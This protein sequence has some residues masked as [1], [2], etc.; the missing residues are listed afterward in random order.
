M[1]D[2][3]D[4]GEAPERPKKAMKKA[5]RA[6]TASTTAPEGVVA[7]SAARSPGELTVERAPSAAP[8]APASLVPVPKELVVN[9]FDNLSSTE[10]PDGATARASRERSFGKLRRAKA[11]ES[12][13]RMPRRTPT[14]GRPKSEHHRLVSPP[15]LL[16]LSLRVPHPCH[17][18]RH[19]PL[20]PKQHR[21]QS[22]AML[23]T[24]LSR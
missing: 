12:G 18:H 15:S 24:L 17:R 22:A 4:K 11:T 10:A 5:P 7:A 9:I 20:R 8:P 1:E 3:E 21:T 19:R 14:F 6:K 16:S 13:L 2:G 23:P